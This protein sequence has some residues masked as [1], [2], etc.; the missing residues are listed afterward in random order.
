[1]DERVGKLLM[2]EAVINI[3]T[4]QSLDTRY[5]NGIAVEWKET[6]KSMK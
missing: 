6:G 3:E 1:M 4:I 5:P 2:K